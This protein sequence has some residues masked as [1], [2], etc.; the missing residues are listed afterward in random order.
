[1]RREAGR[2]LIEGPQAL[3]VALGRVSIADVFATSE[4]SVRQPDLLARLDDAGAVIR[5]VDDAAAAALSETVTPQG[6][7][8]VGV[9]PQTELADL[10]PAPTLLVVL[11][12]PRDP[13]N[14]GTIIRTA[15]AAGADAVVLAGGSADPFG[16]KAIRASAGS[17]F[18][19]P[20]ID[21]GEPMGVLTALVDRGCRPIATTGTAEHDLDT[22][23]DTGELAAPTAWLFG[24][25]AHGLPREVIVS[26]SAWGGTTLRVPVYGAAESLNVSAAAAVCLF[27]SARAQR[28]HPGEGVGG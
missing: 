3:S 23:I 6:L 10:G 8:G 15:D 11:V 22:A 16:G 28:R 4:A 2:F 5:L 9:L 25:E 20:V 24:N 18:A 12:E 7:V 27:A 14:L 13:G 26:V 21:G 1:M 19:L 17:V